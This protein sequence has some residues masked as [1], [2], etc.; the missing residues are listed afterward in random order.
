MNGWLFMK[1]GMCR[2]YHLSIL[3]PCLQLGDAPY[4]DESTHLLTAMYIRNLLTFW[5]GISHLI[6]AL[7][8]LCLSSTPKGLQVVAG[9]V[10]SQGCC[11]VLS[12]PL[13]SWKEARNKP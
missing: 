6:P 1:T 2:K 3:I 5:A 10:P 7:L 11:S 9:S 4:R 12:S 13:R 8:Y